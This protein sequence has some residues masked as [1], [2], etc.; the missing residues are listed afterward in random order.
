VYGYHAVAAS[1]R[2]ACRHTEGFNDM[3]YHLSGISL[4]SPYSRLYCRRA[5][6]HAAGEVNTFP[7]RLSFFGLADIGGTKRV[8]RDI[9]YIP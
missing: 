8:L 2:P 3:Q 9:E 7:Y 1:L 6:D 5:V 4:T